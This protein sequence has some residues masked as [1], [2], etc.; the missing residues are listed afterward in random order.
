[1]KLNFCWPFKYLDPVNIHILSDHLHDICMVTT[2]RF[3]MSV[4]PTGDEW[5]FIG[6]WSAVGYQWCM[7]SDKFHEKQNKKV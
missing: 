7:S 3:S 6:L 4:K 2:T 5:R 1:M